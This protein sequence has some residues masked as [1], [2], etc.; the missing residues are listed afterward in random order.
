M[1]LDA[2]P[3]HSPVSKSNKLTESPESPSQYWELVL[4]PDFGS[5]NRPVLCLPGKGHTT[6]FSPSCNSGLGN[7]S[8]GWVRACFRVLSSSPRLRLC[9]APH[10]C[11]FPPGGAWRCGVCDGKRKKASCRACQALT[12]TSCVCLK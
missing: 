7:T 11:P 1:H 8:P 4:W 2:M 10:S 5:L 12:Y 6:P 9:W 3:T